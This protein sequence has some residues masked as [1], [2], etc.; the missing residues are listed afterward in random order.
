MIDTQF[1]RLTKNIQF[2]LINQLMH[3]L[4]QIDRFDNAYDIDNAN[5]IDD[6]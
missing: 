4:I 6:T 1:N 3:I 5:D 2:I